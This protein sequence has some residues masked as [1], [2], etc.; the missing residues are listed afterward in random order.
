MNCNFIIL[1]YINNMI[2]HT[3]TFTLNESVTTKKKKEKL[4]SRTEKSLL[5][6]DEFV[7]G[8]NMTTTKPRVVVNKKTVKV[9]VELFQMYSKSSFVKAE[10]KVKKYL[11][12]YYDYKIEQS[13]PKKPNKNNVNNSKTKKNKTKKKNRTKLKNKI[14]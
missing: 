6:S 3:F 13:N 4:A 5:Y 12:K 7:F 9:T 11:N 14:E 8:R 10:N 1:Y 2:T